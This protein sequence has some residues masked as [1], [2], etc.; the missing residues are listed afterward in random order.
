MTKFCMVFG[1]LFLAS[2][3][4]PSVAASQSVAR[5]SALSDGTILDDS[6]G[7][8][9][10]RCSL[11]QTWAGRECIGPPVRYEWAAANAE[12][13]SLNRAKTVAG[14]S[15]WRLPT[16]K[17]LETIKHCST[18]IHAVPGYVSEL[19]QCE[20]R[21]TSPTIAPVFLPFNR[22]IRQTWTSTPGVNNGRNGRM[23]IDFDN[24]AVMSLTEG[25]AS[26][27]LLVRTVDGA[28]GVEALHSPSV[29]SAADVRFSFTPK[30]VQV[31][32][33]GGVSADR[34][35]V[36]SSRT[37]YGEY[38][39]RRHY[40]VL[41]AA[42]SNGAYPDN[43]I[44]LQ[45]LM[46]G[47]YPDDYKG[48]DWRSF[49]TLLVNAG[50]SEDEAR[51]MLIGLPYRQRC[52]ILRN[53]LNFNSLNDPEHYFNAFNFA[54]FLS[55]DVIQATREPRA[56]ASC[57]FLNSPDLRIEDARV[58]L[59][60][61]LIEF[62]PGIGQREPGLTAQLIKAILTVNG[63]THSVSSTRNYAKD[64]SYRDRLTGVLT[65][66]LKQGGASSADL[67]Q[68][69]DEARQAESGNFRRFDSYVDGLGRLAHVL[70]KGGA[71][72][73][74][75]GQTRD[76][77]VQRRINALIGDAAPTQ[78]AAVRQQSADRSAA[79][80]V[81]YTVQTLTEAIHA[82]D[83]RKENVFLERLAS[84]ASQ[85]SADEPAK[86]AIEKGRDELALML[87]NHPHARLTKAEELLVRAVQKPGMGNTV[88]RLARDE[89]TVVAAMN[90]LMPAK[91]DESVAASRRL[92]G[93][94]AALGGSVA[95]RRLD[96]IDRQIEANRQHA[97]RER[98][99][100]E[101]RAAERERQAAQQRAAERQAYLTRKQ[102]GQRVCK[103]G[104]VAFG[105]VDV[106]I[107][108]YV[109]RVE[110]D[111]IQLRIHGTGGQTLHYDGG[112]LHIG[113]V[114][115][116]DYYEWKPCV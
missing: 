67:K 112:P 114:L 57:L 19:L 89:A 46:R 82:G 7:L 81:A 31:S 105:L 70:V 45:Y 108:A 99:A 77:S 110:G 92:I 29:R 98:L 42:L 59:L 107:V 54:R 40:Q 13:E 17:E 88:A 6:N 73:T 58:S 95:A 11:G 62:N 2:C 60:E 80:D 26:F 52:D 50:L 90:S 35:L 44:I 25:N 20:R 76:A 113:R 24:G 72:A 111:K 96:E 53:V 86:A 5:L 55:P 79:Q 37:S 56:E 4:I 84:V 87:I 71:P 94:I 38:D 78:V 75:L 68:V 10:S 27:A 109:E 103:P 14:K 33:R 49:S 32:G 41:E 85:F 74:L 93:Q 3:T 34:R 9:W 63:L 36:R 28:A 16:L 15:D 115:W 61:A 47:Q 51:G 106:T 101:Q 22:P 100:A 65:E 64:I 102:V 91:S 23:T 8:Q 116:D 83:R 97:E 69:M 30:K 66:A 39:T 43:K 48:G 1:A 12:I 104:S 18:G 21:S